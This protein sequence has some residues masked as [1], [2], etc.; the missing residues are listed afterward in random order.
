MNMNS[1][2]AMSAHRNMVSNQMSLMRSLERLSSGQQINRA[3]DN[4]AGLAI[5]EKMRSDIASFET[6][7]R[8]AMDG[9]SLIQT[10]EG[11]LT[12]THSILNRMTELTTRASNGV[13][14]DQQRGI[15]NEEFQALSSEL[16]RISQATNFNGRNLLDGS[17]SNG[18]TLQVGN[19]A[20]Q[21]NRVNISINNM[22]AGGLGLSGVDI[23][24]LESAQSAL[25]L[26]RDAT[27]T[28]S[29]QRASLGAMQ[30][31][32]EHTINSLGVTVENL[33]NAESRIRDTDM[34]REMMNFTRSNILTQASQAMLAQANA[35]A[36][37]F[38][39][40]LR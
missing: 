14:N 27:N 19:T 23:S 13:L 9:I 39:S 10:A 2:M 26:I 40:L 34:A 38:L 31:R 1:I 7:S 37:N 17:L 3:A 8:N 36:G 18:L 12:E 11:A 29:S 22:G 4:A 16:N 5:S 20:D 21:H 32:Q 33:M 25:S 24:S 6:A 35:V 15:L 30:N 28:V